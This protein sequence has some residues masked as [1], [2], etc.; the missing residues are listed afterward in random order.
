V[1][2]TKRTDP[3]PAL[4]ELAARQHGVLSHAQLR[5]HGMSASA[6]GR[7]AQSARLHRIFPGVYALGH[8]PSDPQALLMAATLACGPGAVV[9]HRSAA[10]MLGLLDRGPVS[11][12]VIAPGK[13]GLKIDGIHVHLVRPLRRHETGTVADI[14]CTS[15]ART[16][17]DVAGQVGL[18]TLRSCFERAAARRILDIAAVEAAMTSG[19]PGMP[20]LRALLEEWR[21]VAPI[22]AT[23]R[24]K[25]PLEAMILPLLGKRGLPAPRANAPVDLVE[26]RIEVD[27]LWAEQR[28]VL[29]A[30]SRDFHATDVA[31]ERDRWRDRELMRVDYSSLRVTRIQAENEAEA[32]AAT[33]ARRLGEALPR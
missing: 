19:R 20:T 21:P 24:L 32:I 12:D 16:L 6:I 8:L 26:G 30:D 23:Q 14:P 2:G 10:A 18:R 9:S 7:A 17:V 27:F 25:S 3:W 22:A 31:F 29:E 5:E 13:R 11:I 1:A 15:P 28:F 33:I 4:A